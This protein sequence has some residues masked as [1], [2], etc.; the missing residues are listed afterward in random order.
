MWTKLFLP[1]ETVD[2]PSTLQNLTKFLVNVVE[3]TENDFTR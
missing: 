2:D 1:P 3:D